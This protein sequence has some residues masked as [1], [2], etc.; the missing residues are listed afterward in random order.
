[1]DVLGSRF[2]VSVDDCRLPGGEQSVVDQECHAYRE[3][4]VRLDECIAKRGAQVFPNGDC[5]YPFLINGPWIADSIEGPFCVDCPW[6][7]S[8]S[9][10]DAAIEWVSVNRRRADSGGTEAWSFFHWD[11]DD[12][13]YR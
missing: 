1:M 12:A 10:F 2:G 5:F 8:E 6:W 13:D 7:S 9:C 11:P 4:L 3:S